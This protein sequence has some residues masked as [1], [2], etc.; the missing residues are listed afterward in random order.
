MSYT[1]DIT[2][3]TPEGVFNLR[4]GVIILQDD[5]VLLVNNG[6]HYYPVGGRVKLHETLEQ[7]AIREVFEETGEHFEIDR[8]VFIN[9]GFFTLKGGM[10]DG[11]RFHELSFIFLM[12]PKQAVVIANGQDIKDSSKEWLEWVPIDRL[13]E[14]VVY[15]EVFKTGLRHLPE[16]PTHIV[17]IE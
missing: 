11:K 10:H 9:E 14:L 17:K 2:Y 1:T 7:A 8:L 6:L 16:T 13:N 3:F 4:V 15:P 12:K 5:K